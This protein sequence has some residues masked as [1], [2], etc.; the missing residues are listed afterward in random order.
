MLY[1]PSLLPH[2]IRN[3]QLGIIFFSD[4]CFTCHYIYVRFTPGFTVLSSFFPHFAHSLSRSIRTSVFI[5][6]DMAYL[7]SW[8]IYHTMSCSTL[9]NTFIKLLTLDKLRIPQLVETFRRT[10]PTAIVTRKNLIFTSHQLTLSCALLLP[11][12]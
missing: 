5:A 8:K 6:L 4:G 2:S 11:F 10:T 12:F 1:G 9:L 7:A 3:F